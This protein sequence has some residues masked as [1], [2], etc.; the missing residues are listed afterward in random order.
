MNVYDLILKVK[1]GREA[2]NILCTCFLN[3]SQMDKMM[4]IVDDYSVEEILTEIGIE[5]HINY[6]EMDQ[7]SINEINY[8]IYDLC[9]DT[10]VDNRIMQ[11]VA[12]SD[13]DENHR[14]I[15]IHKYMDKLIT[16]EDIKSLY[17]N[18]LSPLQVFEVIFFSG[19]LDKHIL[20]KYAQSKYS[21][22][23][24][25]TV[26]FW[27]CNKVSQEY[28][29]EY[30]N[31]GFTGEQLKEIYYGVYKNLPGCIISQYAN[32]KYSSKQMASKRREIFGISEDDDKLF[33]DEL[34]DDIIEERVE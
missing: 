20:F 17:N 27:I 1:A 32:I 9:N 28:I 7:K 29:D 16:V 14:S 5:D 12:K 22:E 2:E 33:I 18:G 15:I 13:Y 4:D 8:A 21:R 25:E 6:E 19:Y 34:W 26:Y 23:I 10:Y 3:E 30:I 24:L 11:F 31:R